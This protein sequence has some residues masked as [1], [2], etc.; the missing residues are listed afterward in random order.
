MS[1]VLCLPNF[2]LLKKYVHQVL[3][4]KDHLDPAQ[5]PLQQSII[6]QRGKPCGMFFQVSGPRLLKTYAVWAGEQNRVLFYD[7]T[8]ERF[9]EAELSEGPDPRRLAA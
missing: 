9:A 8:G 1:E 7:S 6:L 5:A 3:C 4:D 2:D